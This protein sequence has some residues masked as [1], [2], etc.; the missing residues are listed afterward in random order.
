MNS[1]TLSLL[2]GAAFLGAYLAGSIPN[3]LVGSDGLFKTN[4]AHD[5]VHIVTAAAFAAMAFTSAKAVRRFMLAF[6]VVYA[7][8]GLLGFTVTGLHGDMGMLLGFICINV[9][10]NFLH[11]GLGAGIFLTGKY[12][13]RPGTVQDSVA[14]PA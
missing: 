5:L 10:D 6:G 12:L 4:T 14:S 13:V 7:L 11:L 2:W 9:L 8:V 1:K 3:P